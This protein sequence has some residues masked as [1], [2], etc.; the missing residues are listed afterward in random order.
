MS[1]T[2]TLDLTELPDTSTGVI[3]EEVLAGAVAHAAATA[4][5]MDTFVFYGKSLSEWAVE[6]KVDIPREPSIEDLRHLLA[7]TGYRIQQATDLYTRANSICQALTSGG[8]LKR[9]DLVA[10]LV[11]RYER[12][13]M[14]RPAKGTLEHQ[15][16]SFMSSTL[17]TRTAANI[18]KSFFR[19]KKDALIETRKVLEQLGFTIHMELKLLNDQP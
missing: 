10:A 6:L 5:F 13:N 18:V 12:G 7:E 9:S 2:P 8:N 11:E 17:H 1:D 4:S 15:A 14:K 3:V 16:D 19:E